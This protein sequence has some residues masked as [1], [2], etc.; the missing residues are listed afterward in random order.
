MLN[1]LYFNFKKRKVQIIFFN[2]W[3]IFE[4]QS[5]HHHHLTTCKCW[6]FYLVKK[7]KQ[8][9]EKK[10]IFNFTQVLCRDS[11]II[12]NHFSEYQV[13]TTLWL[14]ELEILTTYKICNRYIVGMWVLSLSSPVWLFE[15]PWN[16]TF[17]ASLSMDFPGKNTGAGCR[18]LLSW[19]FPTQRLNP[20][21]LH[22]PHWQVDS[23]PMSH[24][25]SPNK[26]VRLL[27]CFCINTTIYLIEKPKKILQSSSPNLL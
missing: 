7:K 27:L 3:I 24:Q 22:L 20:C 11:F 18:F 13:Q 5:L 8:C 23:L 26:Y 19:I 12:W 15:T 10:E 6:H 4:K 21:L 16:V 1:Q 9:K 14:S 17:Q 2:T 25:W